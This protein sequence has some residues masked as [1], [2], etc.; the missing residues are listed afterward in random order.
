MLSE[1]FKGSHTFCLQFAL[2]ETTFPFRRRGKKARERLSHAFSFPFFFRLQSSLPPHSAESDDYKSWKCILEPS[3]P[4][5]HHHLS[6]EPPFSPRRVI[7]PS[8]PPSH[9]QLH[10]SRCPPP[11]PL[12][13]PSPSLEVL[14]LKVPSLLPSEVSLLKLS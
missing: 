10:P 12:S 8:R 3:L 1:F 11:P 14:A 5:N 9:L 4:P 7:P 6:C 13:R 2:S